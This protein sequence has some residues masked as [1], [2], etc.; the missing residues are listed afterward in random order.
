[1]RFQ[2]VTPNLIVNDIERSRA[3]Y[4]DALGF[5]QIATVP[6]QAP[7]VFV[8]MKHEEV[9]VFLNIPPNSDTT[10]SAGTNSLY[11]RMQGIDELA[12][13]VQAA[14][15]PFA[16]EMHTEFYG[17]KEFAVNDPDGYLIIFAEPVAGRE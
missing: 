1:M 11:I 9:N 5:E 4:R 13:K 17:M 3:F 15:V 12:T 14:G 6:E 10:P 16:I 7:F 8:W 2:A